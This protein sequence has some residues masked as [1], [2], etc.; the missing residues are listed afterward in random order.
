MTSHSVKKADSK[1]SELT[2]FGFVREHYR[3]S[4]PNDIV[5]LMESYYTLWMKFH[6]S[7]EAL[8][9]LIAPSQEPQEL[10]IGTF[11]LNGE[12]IRL[13]SEC[14]Y[15]LKFVTL[16][17]ILPRSIEFIAGNFAVENVTRW[18]KVKW[19]RVRSRISITR[20]PL[21]LGR[22]A[23][24]ELGKEP[25]LELGRELGELS[26]YLDITQIKMRY[27][28]DFDITPT[29]KSSG[30]MRLLMDEFTPEEPMYHSD[31]GWEMRI[32]RSCRYN[33]FTVGLYLLF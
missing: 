28:D 13:Y 27:C 1:R 17:A 14:N 23:Q 26:V 4:V 25:Q 33:R 20:H 10:P 24:L 31:N 29:L 22:K 9:Q 18:E 30:T 19:A 21:E 3:H 2:V 8:Q 32:L 6:F 11:T 16:R 15:A 12:L 5:N 7:T